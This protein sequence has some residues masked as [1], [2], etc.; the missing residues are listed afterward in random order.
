MFP[1]VFGAKT[2][3]GIGRG[4]FTGDPEAGMGT[5]GLGVLNFSVDLAPARVGVEIEVLAA[6]MEGFGDDGAY[7]AAVDGDEEAAAGSDGCGG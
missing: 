3:A 5:A 7:F 4:L 2:I 6:P 1:D